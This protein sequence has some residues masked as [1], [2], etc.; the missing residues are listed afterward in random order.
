RVPGPAPSYR[1]E[2]E[3]RQT[4]VY[5]A[6]LQA[7]RATPAEQRRKINVYDLNLERFE[8]AARPRPLRT[9][10]AQTGGVFCEAADPDRLAP[11]RLEY[12][13]DR[14]ALLGL[15]LTGAG[16]EWLLRRATGML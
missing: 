4:G 11:P 3:P 2:I 12:L 13:W 15:M 7:P 14:G 10:D 1:A 8:T 5:V 16:V 6:I 9:L